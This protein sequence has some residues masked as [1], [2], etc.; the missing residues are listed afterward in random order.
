MSSSC[1]ANDQKALPSAGFKL[2][3]QLPLTEPFAHVTVCPVHDCRQAFNDL[4]EC[5]T[6]LLDS[7]D[8]NAHSNTREQLQTDLTR[9]QAQHALEAAYLDMFAMGDEENE[10]NVAQV[11]RVV[12]CFAGD[13]GLPL[14]SVRQQ[15]LRSATCCDDSDMKDCH[16]NSWACI[17]FKVDVVAADGM[18]SAK[19]D[20]A[21]RCMHMTCP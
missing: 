5:S 8:Y 18:T 10:P 16:F 20:C 13:A 19:L 7:G 1:P 4:T 21:G 2:L 15:F 14:T 6:R 9:R 11:G 12:L 3:K 17:C